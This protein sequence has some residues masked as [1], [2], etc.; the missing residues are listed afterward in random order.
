MLTGSTAP[1]VW[2]QSQDTYLPSDIGAQ[3]Q[4]TKPEVNFVV[5]PNVPT[6]TLNNLDTLNND[7][8]TTVY[9]TSVDD[10]TTNPAWLHGVKPDSN[11]KTDGAVSTA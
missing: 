1:Y 2:L 8:N 6:L 4:H 5:V 10:V 11:G 7:G 9:L 3:L